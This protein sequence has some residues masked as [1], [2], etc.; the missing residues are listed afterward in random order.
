VDGETLQSRQPL[1]RTPHRLNPRR[2]VLHFDPYPRNSKSVALLALAAPV[3]PRAAASYF[4]KLLPLT[5]F[6]FL[7]IG[8]QIGNTYKLIARFSL[9]ACRI[10]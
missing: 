7:C 1:D 4:L 9:I 5:L 6:L 10:Q 3:I 8:L 2:G